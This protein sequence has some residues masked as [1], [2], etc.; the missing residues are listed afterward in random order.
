MPID[1]AM[2]A[3]MIGLRQ[4]SFIFFQ[5]AAIWLRVFAVFSRIRPPIGRSCALMEVIERFS[6]T[7]ARK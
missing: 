3:Q 1:V 2:Q 7:L 4:E 5:G 6:F